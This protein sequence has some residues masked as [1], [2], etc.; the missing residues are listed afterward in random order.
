M[1][2]PCWN[3]EGRGWHYGD[4][5]DCETCGG[6][7]INDESR[8]Q[9]MFRR[10]RYIGLGQ[11]HTDRHGNEKWPRMTVEVPPEILIEAEAVAKKLRGRSQF[12]YGPKSRAAIIRMA[13]LEWMNK[14][15]PEENVIEATAEEIFERMEIEQGEGSE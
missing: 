6:T 10:K 11:K 5:S 9:V 7:G 8:L 4:G 2:T 15:D 14:H 3:C 12:G 1:K 13:L